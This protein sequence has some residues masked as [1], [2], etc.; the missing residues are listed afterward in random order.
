MKGV[1]IDTDK[2]FHLHMSL[3]IGSNGENLDIYL[4]NIFN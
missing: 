2:T 3:S 4:R 1:L